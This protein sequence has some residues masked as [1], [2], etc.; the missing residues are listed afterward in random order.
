M[1]IEFNAFIWMGSPKAPH[2]HL[3]LLLHGLCLESMGHT[4]TGRGKF[5]RGVVKDEGGQ[6]LRDSF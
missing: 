3:T 5:C 4:N 2:I 1:Y 6:P